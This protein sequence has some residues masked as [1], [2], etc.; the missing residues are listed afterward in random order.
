MT[1]AAVRPYCHKFLRKFKSHEIAR[2]CVSDLRSHGLRTDGIIYGGDRMGIY[3]L[4]NGASFRNSKV[5]Y[6]RAGSSF[7]TNSYGNS[8]HMK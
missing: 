5:V 7:S 6:D 3:F 2:A 4:E 8:N 1:S